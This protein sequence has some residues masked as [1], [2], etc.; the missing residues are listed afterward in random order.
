[1]SRRHQILLQANKLNLKESTTR[2]TKRRRE[3]CQADV[4]GSIVTSFQPS[5]STTTTST[6]TAAPSTTLATTSPA[7]SASHSATA[8]TPGASPALQNQQRPPSSTSGLS[9]PQTKTMTA[10]TAAP[11]TPKLPWP[12]PTVAAHNPVPVLSTPT[13]VATLPSTFVGQDQRSSY[14]RPRPANAADAT[15]T[16]AQQPNPYL[17]ATAANGH[18]L[19][20]GGHGSMAY[21]QKE[22]GT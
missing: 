1:M 13:S 10:T 6:T 22:N 12:M 8:T 16:V 4:S 15:K 7:P 9:T 17:Y 19:H 21:R 3:E 18:A 20:A 11:P 14:Y 5:T 2:G